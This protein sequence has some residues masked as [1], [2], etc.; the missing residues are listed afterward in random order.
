MMREICV[1]GVEDE[2]RGDAQAVVLHYAV[3]LGVILIASVCQEH[4]Q[5]P[6][7]YYYC[8]VPWYSRHRDVYMCIRTTVNTY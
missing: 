8:S 1:H 3:Y 7:R 6:V 5:Q 2:M 4:A